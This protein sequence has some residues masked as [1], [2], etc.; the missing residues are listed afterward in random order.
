DRS[1]PL[2][3]TTPHPFPAL[4]D[5]PVRASARRVFFPAHVKERGVSGAQIRPP[6]PLRSEVGARPKSDEVV[7]LL[8]FAIGDVVNQFLHILE[9]FI[10]E[11]LVKELVDEGVRLQAVR[12]D[13][14]EDEA[15]NHPMNARYSPGE[16]VE[17]ED[18]HV[19]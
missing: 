16:Q 6:L 9:V 5:R 8:W 19:R 10:R 11:L 17:R 2:E 12:G 18:E 14:K 1:A 13:A 7:S 15:E 3:R 4:L